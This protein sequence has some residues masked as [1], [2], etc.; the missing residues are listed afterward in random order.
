MLAALGI[1]LAKARGLANTISAEFLKLARCGSGE[2]QKKRELKDE[3]S[4]CFTAREV[5]EKYQSQIHR[6]LEH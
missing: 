2:R 3:A 6:P 5:S 4:T 1:R